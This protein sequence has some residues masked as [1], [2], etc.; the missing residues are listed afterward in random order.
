MCGPAL[1]SVLSADALVDEYVLD[2]YPVALGHGVHLFRDIAEPIAL[3]LVRSCEFPQGVN[4]RV[5]EP[6]YDRVRPG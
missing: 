5:Y 3:S 2:V 1:L 4:V 6:A